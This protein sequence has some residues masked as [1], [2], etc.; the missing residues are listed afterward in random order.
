MTTKQSSTQ[1]QK[2]YGNVEGIYGHW[3]KLGGKVNKISM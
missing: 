3:C 2:D 1:T